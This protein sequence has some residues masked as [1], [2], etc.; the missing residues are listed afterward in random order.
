MKS[1]SSNVL[2]IIDASLNR[3][4]E[5]LRVLEEYAR[6]SL[7]DTALTQQL[8]NLRHKLVRVDARMQTQLLRGRDSQGDVGA[9]M[10]VPGESK[11]RDIAGTISANARRV[12]ESLRVME[13]IARDPDLNLETDAYKKARF[14]LYTVEKELLTRMLRKDKLKRLAGL[15]VIIDIAFLSGRSIARVAMETIQ[16]GAKV[17]QL[18]DKERPTRESLISAIELRDICA[19]HNILFIINDSLEVALASDADG[20]HVGQDDLPVNVARRLLPADKILGCSVR[21]LDEAKRAMVEGA[22]YLGVGAIYPTAT[23]QTEEV[24]GPDRLKEIRRALDLPLV[25][26]GGINQTNLKTVMKAGADAAAVISA[27]MGAGDVEKATR[28]LVEIIGG[29]HVK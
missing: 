28:Q 3:I 27:V 8:K 10:E 24:V 17:I 21:T 23:K 12:Q 4:G 13:E 6:F 5:G 16:G 9:D 29:E 25:A 19:Q 14:D 15:Y 11:Q 7:N 20:L 22:D 2:R 18:R 26:I 1:P